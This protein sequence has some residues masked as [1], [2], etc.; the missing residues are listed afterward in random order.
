MLQDIL[1]VINLKYL[2]LAVDKTFNAHTADWNLCVFKKAFV[3]LD[4]RVLT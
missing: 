1:R 2:D 3:L 4:H